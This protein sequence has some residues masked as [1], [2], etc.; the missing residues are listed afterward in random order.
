M[1]LLQLTY[2]LALDKHRH[3]RRA[4]ESCFV[5]QPT[6]STQIQKF[7]EEL[8]VVLFDRTAH[9][10]MPTRIGRQ[11]VAQA[12]SVVAE[13]ERLEQLVQEAAGEMEGELRVGILSTLA[14]YLLPLVIAPF[15]RRYPGVA[16]VFEELPADR[17]AAHIRRDLL[18]AGLVATAV[19]ERGIAEV[20]LFEEPLVGYVAPGH[21]L[22]QRK[23][24]RTEDLHRDDLWL[25]SPGNCFRDQTLEL[26]RGSAQAE[27]PDAAEQNVV[28]FASGNLETLQ[29]LVDRGHGMTLLPLLAV[30]VE[31]SHAPESVR[32]F[33]SPA[34][35]RTVRLVHA[36]TLVKRRPIEALAAEIVEA[37]APILP[38]GS[39]LYEP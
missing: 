17:I 5:T 7:E 13:A 9:P 24:L 26:L 33:Q 8:G 34:P 1:T 36:E 29:R 10:I 11:V 35:S 37:V 4:A 3:F 2:L 21:R 23:T 6:L 39:I 16:L 20:P 31:G 32:P 38:E 18:D 19:T 14:P 30:Q 12:R 15:S 27:P 22:Y 28:E 25:M